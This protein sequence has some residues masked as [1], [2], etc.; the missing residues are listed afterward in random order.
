VD[1]KDVGKKVAL[2]EARPPRTGRWSEPALRVLRERYL[3]RE[4]GEVRE[5]PEE[6]CWRVALAIAKAEARFGRSE[7]AVSDVATAC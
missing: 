1:R 3:A 6:M 7:A 5:T 2:D 4:H